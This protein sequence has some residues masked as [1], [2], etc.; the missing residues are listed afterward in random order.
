LTAE[1][2][3][4]GLDILGVVIKVEDKEYPEN[5][6]GGDDG[7]AIYYEELVETGFLVT[8]EPLIEELDGNSG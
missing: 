8:V 1:E 6:Y 7:E 3:I 5:P 4:R 2:T